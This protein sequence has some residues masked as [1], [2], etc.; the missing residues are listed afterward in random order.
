MVVVSANMIAG[1]MAH[2][3]ECVMFMHIAAVDGVQ[4]LV[5]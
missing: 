1:E 3:R 2:R 4:G 5:G